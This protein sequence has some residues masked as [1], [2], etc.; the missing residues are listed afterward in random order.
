M[1]WSN[2]FL[3]LPLFL[4]SRRTS[5]WWAWLPLATSVITT[6]TM[7]RTRRWWLLSPHSKDHRPP[8]PWRFR[9]SDPTKKRDCPPAPPPPPRPLPTS[10]RPAAPFLFHDQRVKTTMTTPTSCH[11]RRP[12]SAADSGAQN[13][14]DG[15][16][17]PQHFSDS[18]FNETDVIPDAM[19][20][21]VRW[22][23]AVGVAETNSSFAQ[24]ELCC[25]AGPSLC[26]TR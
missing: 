13:P 5:V 2:C 10:S 9:R 19:V 3:F 6:T 20:K 7:N 26:E 21:E 1:C 8:P 25:P 17:S 4:P 24:Q 16:A 18:V 22:N 11:H 15:D 14:F 12:N 23:A